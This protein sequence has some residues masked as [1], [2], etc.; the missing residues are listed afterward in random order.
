MLLQNLDKLI[1]L[2]FS[3]LKC[4]L[5]GQKSIKNALGKHGRRDKQKLPKKP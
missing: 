1:F 5:A 4:H 3:N 2:D